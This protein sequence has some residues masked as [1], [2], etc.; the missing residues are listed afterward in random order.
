[1]WLALAEDHFSRRVMG[2]RLFKKKP[3][4]VQVRSFLAWTFHKA[5][6]VAKYIV[7][8][9]DGVFDCPGFRDWCE[10]HGIKPR[11]GAVGRHGSLAVIERLIRTVKDE[12]TRRIMVPLRVEK[13]R[14]ELDAFFRWYNGQRPHMA[15]RGR[16]P[17]EVY[18][19]RKAADEQPRYEPRRKYPR[20]AWCASTQTKVKGRR[21]VRLRLDVSHFEGRKHLP[22]LSVR[23]AA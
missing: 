19:W 11:Y 23:P 7:C 10:R 20:D 4:S 9:R 12:C 15:L 21:G 16:T 1:M 13:V 14:A 18:F 3:G 5:T 6:A 2:F 22:L 8:D 17:D